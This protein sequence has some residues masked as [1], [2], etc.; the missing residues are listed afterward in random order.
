ML[1]FPHGLE[2]TYEDVQPGLSTPNGI[3]RTSEL[4]L[5]PFSTL[6]TKQETVEVS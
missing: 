2:A 3:A 4:T 1:F 6:P 5:I